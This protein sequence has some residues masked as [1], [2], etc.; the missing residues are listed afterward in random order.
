MLRLGVFFGWCCLSWI[1]LPSGCSGMWL[2]GADVSHWDRFWQGIWGLVLRVCLNH[3]LKSKSFGSDPEL[4]HSANNSVVKIHS[5]FQFRNWAGPTVL[6]KWLRPAPWTSN[7][8]QTHRGSREF[9]R[10]YFLV[11][12]LTTRE[13]SQIECTKLCWW[14]V[15]V[16]VEM[17]MSQFAPAECQYRGTRSNSSLY[18]YLRSQRFYS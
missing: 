6:L 13:K 11:N 16:D 15:S 2:R 12:R 8:S 3:F 18:L 9:R 5:N 14:M 10:R 17:M 4:H 7:V 1:S